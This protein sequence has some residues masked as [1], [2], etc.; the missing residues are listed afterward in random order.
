[1]TKIILSNTS[2]KDQEVSTFQ[3]KTTEPYYNQAK[4]YLKYVNNKNLEN[5]EKTK[6][7]NL[8][9]SKSEVNGW[10]EEKRLNIM[11]AKPNVETLSSAII[12]MV[13]KIEKKEQ[14]EQGDIVTKGRPVAAIFIDYVQQLNTEEKEGNREQ[15]IQKI[16]KIMQNTS[17]D[18]R[19]KSAII[20]GSQVNREATS[21][22][23]LDLS[24]MRES[25]AIENIANW[26]IGVWDETSAEFARLSEWLTE[27]KSKIEKIN[28]GFTI[29]DVNTDNLENIKKNIETQL[30]ILGLRVEKKVQFKILKNRSGPSN[31]IYNYRSYSERFCI[32][33]EIYSEKEEKKQQNITRKILEDMEKED[34]INKMSD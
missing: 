20:L 3:G 14:N 7:V 27:V 13:L 9:K 18:A 28:L 19:V 33:N 23:N 16:C 32:A 15:E 25:G 29:K 17:I 24:K 30:T 10:I 34:L 22:E 12:E 4:E 21:V 8:I 6:N 1:M 11:T 31:K 2:I 26:V 5:S